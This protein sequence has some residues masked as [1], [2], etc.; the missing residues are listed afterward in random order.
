MATGLVFSASMK[1]CKTCI[2][3][4]GE[5]RDVRDYKGCQHPRLN[6]A[7]RY[8][9]VTPTDGF[10][11]FDGEPYGGNGTFGTGPDFGCIHHTEK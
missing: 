5:C 8:H 9:A 2:Y 7:E 10:G 11:C 6:E 1:T 4:T 3:W